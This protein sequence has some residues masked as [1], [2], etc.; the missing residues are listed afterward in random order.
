LE[1]NSNNTHIFQN[2]NDRELEKGVGIEIYSTSG[3]SGISAIYKKR[4][5]DFIVKEITCYL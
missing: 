3:F 4:Y 1:R 2:K 5:K